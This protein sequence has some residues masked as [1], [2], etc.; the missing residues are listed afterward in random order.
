[1]INLPAV[2]RLPSPPHSMYKTKAAT[3]VRT[4]RVYQNDDVM[5]ITG[6][7]LYYVPN[8][9]WDARMDAAGVEIC[10]GWSSVYVLCS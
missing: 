2:S 5:M 9:A 1:M 7:V 4:K 6:A 8:D 3:T 10:K